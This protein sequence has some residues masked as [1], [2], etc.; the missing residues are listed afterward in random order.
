MKL[1]HR[2]AWIAVLFTYLQVSLGVTVRVNNAGLS[3]PD[4]P[5]CYNKVFAFPDIGALLE[6]SHRYNATSV[7]VLIV[8][9]TISVL[10]WARKER[11]VLI[12][13]LI[14]LALLAVEIVLGGLT[15]LWKLPSTIITAHLGTAWVIFAMVITVAVMSGK[16][17]PGWDTPNKEDLDKTRKFTL[18]AMTTAL[19]VYGLMLSGSYVVRSGASLAC[20]G[21]PLCGTPPTWAV[22]YHLADINV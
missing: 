1:I 13:T 22:T 9:L 6:E 4:W 5:L 11:Q 12:P 15:V 8:A 10:I 20:P 7:S 2:I 17:T 14:A 16:Q 21:W 19:F 3:C 18:L